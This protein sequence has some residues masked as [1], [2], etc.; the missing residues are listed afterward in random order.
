ML[1]QKIEIFDFILT[2]FELRFFDRHNDHARFQLDQ[3]QLV[4]NTIIVMETSITNY[5]T[6]VD[7]A[8]K[9]I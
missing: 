8:Q 4:R 3:I 7:L 6:T 2:K 1:F 5:N 9:I